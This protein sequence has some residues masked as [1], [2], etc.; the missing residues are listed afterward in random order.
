MQQ[1]VLFIAAS[2]DGFIARSDGGIDWLEGLPNP[3]NSDHGYGEFLE[4]IGSILMGRKTYEA[5]MGFGMDWPY[6]GI[7]TF[8]V[9]QQQAFGINSPDTQLVRGEEVPRLISQLKASSSK[10]IWLVGGGELA[11]WFLNQD[12]LDQ[13]ILTLIPVVLGAGIPLFAPAPRESTWDL[14][15]AKPYSSG[16]VALYYDIKRFT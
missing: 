3:D 13:I 15:K 2:L 8:V 4:G 7:K 1:V 5:I 9:S 6:A 14:K 16:A 10:D 11:T 12:L